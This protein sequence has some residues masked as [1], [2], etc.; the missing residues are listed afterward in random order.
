MIVKHKKPVLKCIVMQLFSIMVA[1]C[2]VFA[3]IKT[4]FTF[5]LI[6]KESSFEGFR[7]FGDSIVEMSGKSIGAGKSSD[8]CLF[9]YTECDRDFIITVSNIVF[10]SVDSNTDA[11]LMIRADTAA[12]AA[13]ITLAGSLQKGLYLHYRLPN[14]SAVMI[15]MGDTVPAGMR[16]VREGN[17]F[18][19]YYKNKS[20]DMYSPIPS[21][22]IFNFPSLV[23]IGLFQSSNSMVTSATV[24]FEKCTGFYT[25]AVP[26]DSTDCIPVLFDFTYPVDTGAMGFSSNGLWQ[27]D[28]AGYAKTAAPGGDDSTAILSTPTFQAGRFDNPVLFQWDVMFDGMNCSGLETDIKKY[29]LFGIH[30]LKVCQ[31]AYI[32]KAVIGSNGYI[33]IFDYSKMYNADIKTKSNVYIHYGTDIY[34]DITA[35]GTVAKESN[36]NIYGNVYTNTQVTTPAIVDKNVPVGCYDITVPQYYNYSISPGYYNN[37]YLYYNA[38]ITLRKGT[39]YFRTFVTQGNAVIHFNVNNEDSVKIYVRDNVNFGNYTKM[40]YDNADNTYSNDNKSGVVTLYSDQIYNL[41]IGESSIISGFLYAPHACIYVGDYTAVYGGGMYAYYIQL[42]Y[43]TKL[44]K[45]DTQNSTQQDVFTVDLCK[46]SFCNE[47]YTITFSPNCS[48]ATVNRDIQLYYNNTLLQ[49][50][51]S[52]FAAPVNQ[53]LQF[54]TELYPPAQDHDSARVKVYYNYGNGFMPVIDTIH[55]AL[56]AVRKASF[57]YK[58]GKELSNNSAFLDNVRISCEKDTCQNI[59][60]IVQPRDTAVYESTHVEFTV[61]TKNPHNNDYQWYRND[62]EIS[63]AHSR[64]L[65]INNVIYPQDSGAVF[66]CLITNSCDTL[67]T[68][69]AVLTVEKCSD[70]LILSHPQNYT[71][72]IGGTA[73]FYV[74]AQGLDL[75]YQWKRNG[76]AI[77]GYTHPACTVT[78]ISPSQHYDE[79]SVLITNGCERSVLSNSAY[80]IIDSGI[81]PCTI[82]KQPGSDTV[83]VNDRFM[84]SVI[85]SCPGGEYVWYKNGSLYSILDNSTL[86]TEPVTINDNGAEFYCIVQNQSNADTSQSAFLTV[87][88]PKDANRLITISGFIID[89]E[90]KLVAQNSTEL[91]D[92]IVR[93]YKT[94]TEGEPVY[95]ERFTENKKL[96]VTDGQF[97]VM[98]GRGD[99]S[100]NLQKVLSSHENTYAEL[101]VIS[102]STEEILGP[103]LA[104]TSAPYAATTGIVVLYG[105]GNPNSGSVTASVGTLYVDMSNETTWKKGTQK[106]ILLE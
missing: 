40:K 39:Y 30:S 54:K 70:P 5:S 59:V 103:R 15:D 84:V 12:D 62:V 11:G 29:A 27:F 63:Q 38:H 13:T 83:E 64:R 45:T 99:A 6:G 101:A 23:K 81:A 87:I 55:S 22:Y 32:D 105:N 104:L 19:F 100:D 43:C 18:T 78:S 42:G 69:S 102:G 95:T 74:E 33:E 10:Y 88:P 61:E 76:V 90:G 77:A 71:T 28:T 96:L 94:R 16:I 2:A 72:Y 1:V 17:R 53:W 89:G 75:R 86:I 14:S 3:Q 31:N 68:R 67:F 48:C 25:D 82:V 51:S 57:T 73:C 56:N 35:G 26:P 41:C 65:F 92:F 34:G 46:N 85:A 7:A 36:V 21:H 50:A 97:N 91:I 98:L 4:P 106:W 47:Y 60:I 9:A 44:Y 80:V 58:T 24:K 66:K 79:Y 49:S 20:E 93:L 52:G 8:N 37:L